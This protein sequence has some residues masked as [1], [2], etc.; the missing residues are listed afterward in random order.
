MIVIRQIDPKQME[1]IDCLSNGGY[2]WTVGQSAYLAKVISIKE[3][4]EPHYR[5][6][7]INHKTYTSLKAQGLIVKSKVKIGLSEREVWV[8]GGEEN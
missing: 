5:S 4:G 2:I 7:S 3:N 1:V 8:L 6:V